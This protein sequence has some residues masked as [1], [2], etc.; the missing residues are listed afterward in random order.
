MQPWCF[1]FF[2]DTLIFCLFWD[3][4]SF[5]FKFFSLPAPAAAKS[6]ATPLTPRQSGLLGVIDR[7]TTIGVLL[8][9]YFLPR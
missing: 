2:I 6:L 1:S 9:K 8:S 3:L 5:T 4:I 7:S